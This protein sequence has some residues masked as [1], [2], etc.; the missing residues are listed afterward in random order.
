[1][2]GALF[3]CMSEQQPPAI[4]AIADDPKAVFL[5]TMARELH[6]AGVATD[7]LEET[8][9]DVASAIGLTTQIFALP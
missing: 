8:L 9:A 3:D 4:S 5:A 6:Q 2:N 1:M 7:T